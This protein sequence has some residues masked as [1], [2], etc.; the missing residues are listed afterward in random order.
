[1]RSPTSKRSPRHA[2]SAGHVLRVTSL[3]D[4]FLG[5]E[6]SRLG[7]TTRRWV[8]SAPDSRLENPP[9]A[10]RAICS[11]APVRIS[12]APSVHHRREGIRGGVRLQGLTLYAASVRPAKLPYRD[13]ARSNYLG[14]HVLCLR[15]CLPGPLAHECV[16]PDPEWLAAGATRLLRKPP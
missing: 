8:V 10:A 14:V 11:I 6:A 7:R 1:M 13:A 4:L 15:P 16:L 3:E 5:P 12:V 2:S 9:T